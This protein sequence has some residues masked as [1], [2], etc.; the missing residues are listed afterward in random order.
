MDIKPS[1]EALAHSLQL[2]NLIQSKIEKG[3]GWLPFSIYMDLALYAPGLGY[4]A[5]GAHKIGLA[6]DFITA[7]ELSPWF[8]ASLAQT[9]RPVLAFFKNK[10][11]GAQ[12][13]EFGAGSGALA[14]S[15]LEQ[16]HKEGEPPEQYSILEVSPDLRQRQEA[17]LSA[18]QLQS[19]CPTK[20]VWLDQLPE[21]FHG[22]ILANEVI[23]AFPVELIV[24][25]GQNWHL[26]GV[27]KNSATSSKEE[28]SF[29]L[30]DGPIIEKQQLPEYLQQVSDAL[31]DGYQT[32]IHP[33]AQAWIKSIS[34]SLTQG[35]FLTLDYGFPARE[36]YH[37]Q[38][39]SGTLMAHYRHHATPDPFHL[40]GLSDITAHVEWTSLSDSAISN[41]LQLLG[42]QSQAAYLLNAGISD[43][44]LAN[45]DPKDA[46]S[47]LPHA[48]A[49]Q[50]LLSEAEM[51]ELF[52]AIAFGQIGNDARLND[53]LENLPGF[54]GRPRPL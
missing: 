12:I 7:P 23:D 8:G 42:Y 27:S 21:T 30:K 14:Q 16:L 11:Q 33:Q 41:G 52:K 37:A 43:L 36:Y 17:R 10:G 51:G 3:G 19:A 46:V 5:A 24:K 20:I 1:T 54:T 29:I 38:R 25:R 45:L 39:S 35:L 28:P 9:I 13:I 22:V 49:V 26:L 48:N 15:V 4:Y 31:P 32:E 34:K 47:Y 50:K 40:P 44:L 6:G 53:I 18:F 2:S